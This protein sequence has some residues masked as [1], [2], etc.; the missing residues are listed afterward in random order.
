MAGVRKWDEN[1][2]ET[3]AVEDAKNGLDVH[4]P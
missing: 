2:G 4:C 3:A 1:Q